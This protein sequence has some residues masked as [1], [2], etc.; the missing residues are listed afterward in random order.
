MVNSNVETGND[1]RET[2]NDKR[3]TFTIDHCPFTPK[4]PV[5]IS[6]HLLMLRIF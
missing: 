1:K 6:Q 4:Q 5:T 3:E 2:I